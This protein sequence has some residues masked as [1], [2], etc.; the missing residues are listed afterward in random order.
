MIESITK[1]DLENKIDDYLEGT[2]TPEQ[3]DELWVELIQDEYYLEY[4]KTAASLKGLADKQNKPAKIFTLTG[5]KQVYVTAAVLIMSAVLVLYTLYDQGTTP[6]VEPLSTLELDYYRSADGT[7]A[8]DNLSEVLMSVISAANSGDID[9]AMS[10]V[11]RELDTASDP[12][13]QHELMI[14]AGSILYNAGQY[15][16][17]LAWFENAVV[18]D[19]SD[20]QM[21]ERNYWYLGN[22]YFQLNMI[23]EAKVAMENAY[24]LNGAYSRIAESYLKALSE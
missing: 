2:L 17:A 18:I 22:T 4:L 8:N 24:E 1:K 23:T 10:I 21:M 3:V 14:T 7:V 19:T 15:D 9:S 5:M 20:M 13:V 11:N 12:A 6:V 16:Q